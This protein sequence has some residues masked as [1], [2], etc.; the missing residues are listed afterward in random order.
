[1]NRFILNVKLHLVPDYSSLTS[2]KRIIG[3]EVARL[4]LLEN[5]VGGNQNHVLILI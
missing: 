3:K 2:S 5:A 4:I 1:V